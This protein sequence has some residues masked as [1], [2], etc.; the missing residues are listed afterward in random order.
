MSTKSFPAETDSLD[1]SVILVN[2]NSAEYLRK[3][4]ASIFF[5]P[6]AVSL[7]VLVVDNASYDGAEAMVKAEYPQAIFIQARGNLG[8]AAA[9]NLGSKSSRG[10]NLLF[11]NPDTVVLQS[12]ISD[13]SAALDSLPNTGILGCRILNADGSLQTSAVQSFPT[14]LNQALDAEL[15]RRW[16]PRSR[17]WGMTALQREGSAP[18]AVEMVSG[19]CLMIKRRVFEQ[20][21][22][23]SPEYFMYA[24]D[25]DLCKKA[26]NIGSQVRF[27]PT[28]GVIHYGGQSTKHQSA[29]SFSVL[30][31]QHSLS[32]Y[33]TKFHS[34]A[35]AKAFRFSRAVCACLRLVPASLMCRLAG[36]DA[37]MNYRA[38]VEKWQ[39]ILRWALGLEKPPARASRTGTFLEAPQ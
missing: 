31:M 14:I 9:N 19:A 39:S 29:N 21:G 10:R 6:T 34:A 23:F 37:R 17:L 1:T 28:A 13:M 25:V 26:S 4:L 16:F 33:F 8:F 20:V 15:L 22:G 2:W 35:Y 38:S 30:C 12:A 24:E 11:L 27:L 3:C 36:R 5:R 7:E 18:V 32:L